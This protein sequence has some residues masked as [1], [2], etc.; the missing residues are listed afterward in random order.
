VRVLAEIPAQED[1]PLRPGTLRR[2]DLEAF[3]VLL[4]ELRGH[5]A[6]LA[7]GEPARRRAVAV[8]LATAAAA[9]GARTALLEC[10]LVNPSLAEAL[11]LAA[12]PGLREYLSGEADAGS[13]LEPLALAGP[14]SEAAAEPLVC[15]VAGRPSPDGPGLL[16]SEA[17]RHAAAKLRSAY[18]LLVLE[19]PSADG[20]PGALAAVAAVADATLACVGREEPPPS[21]SPPLAGL[22]VQG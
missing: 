9:A 2:R 15:V 14:G 5:R 1:G 8:G 20:E 19:G 22:V 11:G 12:A 13:I 18:E 21:S 17:F 10:D 16:E 4:E 3:D 6:V 7:I